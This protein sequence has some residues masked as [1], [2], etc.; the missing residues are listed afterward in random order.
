MLYETV[1]TVLDIKSE[2]GLR[3]RDEDTFCCNRVAILTLLIKTCTHAHS[4]QVLA[5]NILGRFLLNND[6]N[7]RSVQI[8][9]PPHS[10]L[11][12]LHVCSHSLL[13]SFL[14]LRISESFYFF[15]STRPLAAALRAGWYQ[16][17][18]TNHFSPGTIYLELHQ[19][20]AVR[21]FILVAQLCALFLL[22]RHVEASN[23]FLM[24]LLLFLLFDSTYDTWP[25]DRLVCFLPAG[26]VSAAD[27]NRTASFY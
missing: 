7:I 8:L 20:V 14:S 4:P 18:L 19:K 17:E 24:G 9:F 27:C 1:L 5:V 2:S 12:S 23:R 16:S 13:L 21:L 15:N 26:P 10:T 11:P 22:I 25:R 6:R 3:V